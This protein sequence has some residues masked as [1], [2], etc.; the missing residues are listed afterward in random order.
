[1]SREQDKRS[2]SDEIQRAHSSPNYIP[3]I[4]AMAIQQEPYKVHANNGR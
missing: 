3:A 1:M 4:G 2:G